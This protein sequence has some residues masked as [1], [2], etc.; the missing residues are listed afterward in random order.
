MWKPALAIIYPR[1]SFSFFIKNTQKV[2]NHF[3][4][5]DS[6]LLIVK[7]FAKL[8]KSN[9]INLKAIKQ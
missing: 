1:K 7:L 4:S 8:R 5:M 2:N 9:I 3:F 6:T